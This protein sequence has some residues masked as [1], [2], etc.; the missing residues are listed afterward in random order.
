M[1]RERLVCGEKNFFSVKVLLFGLCFDCCFGFW[2]V[3]LGL[4][5]FG[6]WCASAWF[7]VRFNMVCGAV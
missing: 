5:G 4:F 7:V 3:F 6:L 1:D 2:V